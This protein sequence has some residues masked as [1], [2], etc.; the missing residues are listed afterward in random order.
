MKI[1]VVFPQTEIGADPDM[2]A[3]F[4]TTAESLG[5]DHLIAYDHVLGASTA[6]RPDWKGPYNSESMFHEPLVLF[7]YLAGLTKTIELVTGVIILPQRQTALVAKQAACVDVLSKG[8]LRLGVGTGWNEVEYEALGA[9]FNDRG[10]RSEEQIDVLR[11][12]WRDDTISYSGEHHKITDAGLNPLPPKKN[13]PIWLGG[14]APQVIDRVGRLADGWLPF[15]NKN[16]AAQIEQ[17]HATAKQ[18]GRD[19]ASIGIECIIPSTSTV[20]QVKS[21]QDKGVTHVAM[22]TMNQKLPGPAAHVDAITS[23]RDM[24]ANALA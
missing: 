12:L 8:R 16:L 11:R 3:K 15:V 9:N 1:G 24:L 13:I 17:V 18:A 20:D 23:A 6:S 2:V 10:H 5:Y 22:V 7:S 19:P 21:L 14:M 4:A